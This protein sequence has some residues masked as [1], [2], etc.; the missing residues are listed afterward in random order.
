MRAANGGA[1]AWQRGISTPVGR[2]QFIVGREVT[3]TFFGTGGEVQ[4]LGLAPD[5]SA[6]YVV[7]MRS[8]RVSIPVLEYRPFRE[9]ATTQASSLS[10]QIGFGWDIPTKVETK[11]PPGVVAPELHS[12]T[13]GYLRMQFDWR[14]YF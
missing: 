9:F 3:A 13:F 11:T 14:R 12:T 4:F 2:F 7:S 6:V 10:F 1:I 5:L 8:I